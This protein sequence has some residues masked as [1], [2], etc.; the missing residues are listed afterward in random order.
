MGGEAMSV[1]MSIVFTG[2]CALV[3]DGDRA[4][5][6]VLLVDAQG[7]GRVNGVLLPEHSPTLVVSLNSLAN[8]ETSDP[9]RVI[10]GS[11]V[12]GSSVEQLGL[13][14]LTGSEVRIRVQGG[15]SQA[16]RLFRPTDGSS[17]WP[18]PP[19]AGNDSQ[20][21]RDLRFVADMKA[22]AGDGRINPALVGNGNLAAELPKAVSARI[23]LDAGLLE[24]GIPS[25]ESY[26]DDVFEFAG[27]G[28]PP[29]LQQAV[30]DTIRWSLDSDASGVVIEITPVAGGPAKRLVLAPSAKMHTLYVSNLP[31][32]NV[33]PDSHHA[34]T[35]E[36]MAALHFG[37]YYEL[38]YVKPSERALPRPSLPERRTTGMAGGPF[39]PPAMFSRN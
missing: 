33:H 9:T 12:G 1:A 30:T 10:A 19:R 24:A 23:R 27:T 28:A 6:E 5:A 18:D 22:L 35:S 32:E 8:A 26:R 37:A 31:S 36:Q 7:V 38:L 2:L 16:L 14:D 3:T 29:R 4:P 15:Q 34:V 39:C 20:S 21:W 17:S 25:Q 11:Q 13:W